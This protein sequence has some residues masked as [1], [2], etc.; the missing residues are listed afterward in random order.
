MDG[1][2]GGLSCT[3]DQIC[4]AGRCHD[5]CSDGD[6]GPG[7][8]CVSGACIPSR[9]DA[10]PRPDAGPP[11]PCDALVCDTDFICHP[12]SR[13]CARCSED[14]I[15][16]FGEPGNCGTGLSPVCDISNGTCQGVSPGQCQPC[17]FDDQCTAGDGSFVGS[18][19]LRST[20]GWR[21]QVCMRPCDAA[22]PC[23]A[24]LA[25]NA[26]GFCEP[27]L[28]ITCTTWLAA[29]RSASCLSDG[30][31]NPVG[32]RGAGAFFFNTCEGEVIPV[33]DPEAG[34]ADAGVATL[35]TCVQPC[36]ETMDCIRAASGE[37]CRDPGTGLVC[38]P[39]VVP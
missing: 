1:G 27:P 26:D 7:E 11:D 30:E 18:C 34:I 16:M 33:A 2:T 12:L 39:P 25:C 37:V 36:A 20:L 10:G 4:V 31:C 22:T 8:S 32:S 24:G 23:A 35:G 29:G 3:G 14:Q 15:G 6:C 19:V 9:M 17:N 21:E 13:E 38:L 28:S 5:R